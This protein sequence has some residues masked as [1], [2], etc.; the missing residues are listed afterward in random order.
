MPVRILLVDDHP[1]FR[2]ALAATVGQ[3]RSDLLVEEYDT[4]GGVL[5][6]L[7]S[8]SG[9]ALVL[10]DLQ[11]TD[12]IGMNGLLSLKAHFPD[13]PVAIVS[14]HDDPETVQTAQACGAS[15]F[16]SK[17]AGL[18]ALSAAI[19]ALIQGEGWFPDMPG[20]A[21]PSALG[22][23]QVR[24]LEGVRR[25]LMNKQIAYELSLS[26]HTI[27]YHLTGIFRKLGCQTR[28]QLLA[29]TS[30]HGHRRFAAGGE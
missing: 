23:T 12:N 5:A 26:E 17:A 4:A 21:V 19:E 29:V 30:D 10:L 14:A 16:I 3:V 8:S 2:Q 1:L 20:E 7:R 18:E 27:K 22:P 24:I 11:L 13:V 9:A 25:G 6:A 28:A 15:G